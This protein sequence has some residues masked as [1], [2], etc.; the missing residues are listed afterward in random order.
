MIEIEQRY[1]V[2][3]PKDVAATMAEHGIKAVKQTH[4]IDQWFIPDTIRNREAHDIWFDEDHGL[5]YRIRQIEQDDGTFSVVID[6]KQHTTA[7]NHNT[8][9]E[10]TV[11]SISTLAEAKEF[12]ANAGYYNWL[13]IDKRRVLFDAND[14]HIEIVLDEIDGLSEKIGVGAAL[15][16]EYKGNESRDEALTILNSTASRLGLHEADLFE[17]SLTVAAMQVLAR[18]KT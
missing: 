5:A 13:T 1:K 9:Q 12:L 10:G 18:F 15:E 11:D 6:S 14:P 7:S 2:A 3:S 4:I 16:I 8:F 17:K